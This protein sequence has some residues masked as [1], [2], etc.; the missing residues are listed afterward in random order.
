MYDLNPIYF[1]FFKFTFFQTILPIKLQ[2]NMAASS[3]SSNKYDGEIVQVIL[4]NSTPFNQ[5]LIEEILNYFNS[6]A[7]CYNRCITAE[8]NRRQNQ[9]MGC[10][11]FVCDACNL[12]CSNCQFNLCDNCT[13]CC[14][15]CSAYT[16]N[17]SAHTCEICHD[18]VCTGCKYVRGV[19]IS[20]RECYYKDRLPKC[21]ECGHY[22]RSDWSNSLTCKR[23][24][25]CFCDECRADS[26]L[27]DLCRKC[28]Y[29]SKEKLCT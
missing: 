17:C 21:D 23:C 9:C 4:L 19:V 18:N 28:S 24:G 10:Y 13:P 5:D 26:D 22:F 1:I 3:S 7:M 11:R 12:H 6:C 20:C 29:K 16:C 14:K 15:I 25:C 27:D 8:D 2:I